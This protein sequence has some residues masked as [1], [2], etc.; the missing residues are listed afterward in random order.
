MWLLNKCM[1]Q[2]TNKAECAH[3]FLTP[4]MHT[5]QRTHYRCICNHADTSI[6]TN[7]IK[8]LYITMLTISSNNC[9]ND[10][11]GNYFKTKLNSH[12]YCIFTYSATAENFCR[13]HETVELNCNGLIFWYSHSC[14]L[15]T[16]YLLD[17][18]AMH[19]WLRPSQHMLLGTYRDTCLCSMVS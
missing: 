5:Q 2:I 14:F 9:F 19:C 17:V 4:Q 1:L 13:E 15:L 18:L 7:I 6:N 12:Q 10:S 11:G 16:I 8:Q 3:D